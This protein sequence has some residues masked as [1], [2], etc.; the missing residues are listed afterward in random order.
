MNSDLMTEKLV[1][2]VRPVTADARS[3]E[4]KAPT[5]GETTAGVYQERSCELFEG[6]LGI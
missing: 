5:T 2:A 1:C 3:I 6:G 4:T